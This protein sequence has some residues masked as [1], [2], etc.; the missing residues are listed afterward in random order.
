MIRRNVLLEAHF[1]DELLDLTRISQG[2]LRCEPGN[3]RFARSRALRS[4]SV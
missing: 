2:S 1:I 3:R 4:E